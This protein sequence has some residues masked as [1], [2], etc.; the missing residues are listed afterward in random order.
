M[1]NKIERRILARATELRATGGTDGAPRVID[2]Y[3]IVYNSRSELLWDF[4][5]EIAPGAFYRAF[6]EDADVRCLWSH[7]TGAPLGRTTA[8]TLQLTDSE[9]GIQFRCE[10]PDTQVGRDAWVSIQRGDVTGV[11]FGF[12]VDEGGDRWRNE[13]GTIIRTIV[14]GE[15]FEVSPVVFPAYPAASVTT[16][17]LQSDPVTIPADVLRAQAADGGDSD[18]PAQVRM[19]TEHDRERELQLRL[20]RGGSHAN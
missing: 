3:A 4:F 1:T 5:E 12:V 6:G 15:L 14:A 2:G 10:L 11:S 16:R 7:D 18:G 17:T 13:E 9:I 20:I 19:V 8:G